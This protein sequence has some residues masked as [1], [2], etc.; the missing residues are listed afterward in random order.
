MPEQTKTLAELAL[1]VE[2]EGAPIT[3][4]QIDPARW[5]DLVNLIGQ[6]WPNMQVNAKGIK[7]AGRAPTGEKM[8]LCA[9]KSRREPKASVTVYYT[10]SVTWAGIEPIKLDGKARKPR[11]TTAAPK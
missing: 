6:E 5:Q 2:A 9:L 11:N 7:N 10:G 8:V 4:T 1:E 3:T